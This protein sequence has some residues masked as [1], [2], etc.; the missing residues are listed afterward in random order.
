MGNIDFKKL[1][2]E[3]GL[4]VIAGI[5]I[6]STFRILSLALGA[7]MPE[8]NRDLIMLI[9]GMIVSKFG[10][11]VDWFFGSSK[12]SADKTEKLGGG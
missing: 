10:T 9:S 2:R 3:I 6:F 11:V 1:A 4:Y 12:G 7:E 8:K 5:I